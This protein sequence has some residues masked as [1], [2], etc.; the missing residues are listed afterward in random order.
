MVRVIVKCQPTVEGY[1]DKD[2]QCL[3]I[4]QWSFPVDLIVGWEQLL[5]LRVAQAE[6]SRWLHRGHRVS[7]N[8]HSITN[9]QILCIA[10]S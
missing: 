1:T 9:Q 7:D 8:M 2:L 3:H 4:G 5:I 6:S 10:N